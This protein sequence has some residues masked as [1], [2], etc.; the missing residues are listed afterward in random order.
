MAIPLVKAVTRR[1]HFAA[2]LNSI[3]IVAGLI[4]CNIVRY[5]FSGIR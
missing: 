2:A 3:Y 5:E 4:E 1:W